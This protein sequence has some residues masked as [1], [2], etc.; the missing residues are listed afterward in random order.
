MKHINYIAAFLLLSCSFVNAQM[1]NGI[2]SLYG[3]EWINFE[4]TYY[5]IPIAED[6]MYRIPYQSL[7]NWGI[8]LEE[9]SGQRFQLFYL[10]EE[11]PIYVSTNGTL[12]SDDYIEF[13][14]QKNRA[15]LDSYLFKNPEL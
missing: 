4:Q 14:G 8:P 5:K 12:A 9:A 10:G 6:K 1:W 13:Y 15:E 3:N 7:S 11:I 2:D